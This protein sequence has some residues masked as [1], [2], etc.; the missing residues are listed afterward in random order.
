MSR[1]EPCMTVS[2]QKHGLNGSSAGPTPAESHT[3][4][5]QAASTLAAGGMV[6]SRSATLG[7]PLLDSS[8]AMLARGYAWLPDRRRGKDGRPVRA[9]LMGQRAVGMAGPDA[10]EFFY[11]EDHVTRHTA[12]PAPVQ[13]TLFGH[14]PVH[15]LD[16]IAH[17]HRKA[18]F[19]SLMGPGSIAEL[20][21]R[22]TT[23]WD[24]A[25]RTWPDADRVVLFDEAS[26]IIT[27]GVCDWAGVRVTDAEVPP[28]AADLVA[29]VDGFATPGRRHW[30]AR[31]ARRRREAWLQRM[32]EDIRGGEIAPPGT[33]LDVIANHADLDGALLDS[34]TAAVEL[35]NVLRPTV[36]VCWF[37]AYAGHALHRWPEHRARLRS[38]DPEFAEAFAH[39]LRRFYPFAPFVAGRATRELTWQG[40]TIPI[41]ALVFLDIFG[42]NHDQDLWG[43][44]YEFRPQ[45][46]LAQPP[47]ATDLIPQ[48]GG[49][50]HSGHRCP[51][52]GITMA[53][54]TAIGPRLAALDYALPR[55]DL[56]ISLH[57]IP[58]R[59][60]SGVQLADVRLAELTETSQLSE[61]PGGTT[62]PG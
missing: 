43:D 9:R 38:G 47:T 8:L 29:L 1:R 13:S 30:R 10:V 5:R 6:F 46:F 36:A 53:L 49:D 14:G 25:V 58:A 24:D 52:E 39:E 11:D 54:L 61:P 27:R 4:T 16:G 15:T 55:Q 59:P 60:R 45:R 51:G 33:A 3:I 26:R 42:Q 2:E 48:G 7:R 37:V 34:R 44:P 50:P 40:E 19:M 31:R 21:D 22:T 12:I 35:L 17:R 62:P 23:A 28:L 57:R 56:T 18:M 41:D 20:V 32:V